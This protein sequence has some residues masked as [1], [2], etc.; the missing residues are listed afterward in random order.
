MSS[1]S[2][3]ARSRPRLC[4]PRLE[5]SSRTCT[6]SPSETTPLWARPRMAS[7]RSTCSILITSAP[8]S[9]SSAEAAGTNVCSATSSTRTPFMTAVIDLPR[10]SRSP[11][12]VVRPLEQGRCEQ[13]PPREE[14][15]ACSSR[16]LTLDPLPVTPGRLDEPRVR[17]Q[18]R[19]ALRCC[20]GVERVARAA[21]EHER[22]YV[23]L[24]GH[25]VGH[26]RHELVAAGAVREHPAFESGDELPR[27][28]VEEPLPIR[29]VPLEDLGPFR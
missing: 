27:V 7:P 19:D 6:P 3:D 26:T 5:C 11:E 14:S 9:A 1:P 22:R 29:R 2:G 18:L 24:A 16:G 15:I 23:E 10:R 21:P 17:E 13:W 8:Q 20:A 12:D 28:L 25:V 4:L